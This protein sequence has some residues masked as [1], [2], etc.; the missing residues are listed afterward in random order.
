ME[1]TP[2]AKLLSLGHEARSEKRLTEARDYF[3]R[4]VD[5]CRKA[6]DKVLLAEALCGLGQIER[7]LGNAGAALKN[8]AAAVELRR[9]Q[10]APLLLAHAVRHVAD[11]LREQRQPKESAPLYEEALAIFRNHEQTRPLDLANAIRGY[12][13]LKADAGDPEE[14]T[15]LWH[16]A[17]ALYAECGVQAGV[18]ESQ[19]QIAFLM[20]R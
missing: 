6:N 7:D 3:A 4:A 20:G 19:S 1:S 9:N 10:D 18:N 14:A 2:P 15:F 17:M 12:A 5:H 16:E 8:Y 11:I 13:L